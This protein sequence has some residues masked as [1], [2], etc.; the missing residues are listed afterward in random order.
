LLLTQVLG[1]F[2][3]TKFFPPYETEFQLAAQSD[4]RQEGGIT[5][6]FE[7][8]KRLQSKSNLLCEGEL[9][10]YHLRVGGRFDA[11]AAREVGDEAEAPSVPS[12]R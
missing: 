6:R 12:G 4:D 1:D 8:W 10:P 2:D 11:P 5:Y 3:C 9:S 7:T